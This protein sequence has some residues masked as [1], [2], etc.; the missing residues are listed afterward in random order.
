MK[1]YALCPMLFALTYGQLNNKA[2][3]LSGLAGDI[4]RSVMVP[5]DIVTDT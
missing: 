3:T 1:P 4:D 2:G 5:D